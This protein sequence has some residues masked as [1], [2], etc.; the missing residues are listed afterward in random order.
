LTRNLIANSVDAFILALETI[1]RP[2]VAYR[3]EAFCVLFCNAW[4]LLMKAHIFHRGERIF[5]RKRRKQP[6][7]SI[8]LDDC[9]GRIFTDVND[10]VRL[11]IDTVADLRNAA[12]HLVVPFVPPDIMGLFQAGVLNYSRTLQSWFGVSLSDRVPIGMM[13]LVYDFD[14]AKHSLESAQAHRKLPAETVRY[15]QEFQQN[16]RTQA[17]TFGAS[18][19]RFFI[20]IDLTLAIVRNPAKADIFLS[21]GIGGQEALVVEVPKNPDTTHPHRRKEVLEQLKA[22]LDSECTVNSYDLDCVK[23]VYNIQSRA[24]FYYKPKFG[25]AQYSPAYVDWLMDRFKGNSSFFKNARDKR[26]QIQ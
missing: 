4:E 14:P 18:S 5:C 7:R 15:L 17:Q 24:D 26:K 16:I 10:P 21:S 13:A 3:M 9:L 20:P 22:K 1:N 11:N 12:I 25:S 6:R 19:N 8:S 23:I 2:S